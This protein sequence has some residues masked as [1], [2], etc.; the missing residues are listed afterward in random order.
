VKQLMFNSKKGSH[1]KHHYQ[2][3]NTLCPE[4]QTRIRE[5]QLEGFDLF[6]FRL[7]NLE[8]LWG[9]ILEGVFYPIWW[10]PL[11]EVYPL[12]GD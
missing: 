10:D 3:T 1:R 9:L 7:S 8:R 5:R 6:R 2:P 12:Q 4:A 11:H